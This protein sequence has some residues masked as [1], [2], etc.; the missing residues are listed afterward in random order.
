MKKKILHI[1]KGL[2]VGG[3]ET[4]L[5]RLLCGLDQSTHAFFVI[6]LNGP[7]HYSSLIEQLGIPLHHLKMN[8]TNLI[9][10]F[11]HLNL[12]IRNIRPDIVQTWL[13]HS[14]LI[15]GLSAKLWGVKKII[16]G[17]RCEGLN[18]KKTTRWIKKINAVLSWVI[19]NIILTNSKAAAQHHIKAGYN[20]QKIHI[21]YNGFDTIKFSNDKKKS[22][23]LIMQT[24]NLPTNALLLGTLA[25]DTVCKEHNHAYFVLCGQGCHIDN[26]E[27]SAMIN[28][29]I[30]KDRIIL[31]NG[32]EDTA[33][34]LNTLDIF[35]LSSQTEAF[36][37][38]LAEAMLCERP[39]I[40]TDVGEVRNI[41][42]DTGL[43]I[44]KK[45]PIQLATAC[46]EMIRKPKID[47]QALG[48][49]A[50]NR[51]NK[52]YSMGT[53]QTDIMALYTE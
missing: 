16:W 9:P 43:I 21:L 52:H 49:L 13:Y 27:L 15:G 39:C 19:P 35:I 5:Y 36:P 40:A 20:P 26:L 23:Q 51:I 34:Y 6:V 37:N 50:R 18:L 45:D 7:G 25:I 11:Y 31:I 22:K 14:D 30:Y 4:A 29:L 47:R 2:D 44:P 41:I 42:S 8:K 33:L 10:A 48:I 38:S 12:L 46:M 24:Q 32:V 53:H 17:I 1:I 3:S 28:K